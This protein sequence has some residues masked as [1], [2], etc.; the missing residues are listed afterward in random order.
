M[1]DYFERSIRALQLA[2]MSER[3]QQSYTRAVRMLVDF[4]QKT[5]DLIAEPELEDYF[6]HRRNVDKWSSATLR[7]AY[8]G[9]R[10]FFV[11]VLQRDWHIFTYLKSQKDKKLPCILDQEEVFR[12]LGRVKTFHNYACLSTIYAC[13]LRISEAL[14]I[15]VTDID[16]KRMM[17]HVHR[18][19]GAKDRYVPLPQATY[20]LLRSYWVT[21]RNPVFVFPAVGRGHNQAS[22]AQKPMV[23]DS[24]QGA[25]RRAKFDASINK[26]RVS[27]HTLRHCYATHLLEA[28]VN[29]RVVQRYMGHSRLET[30]MVYFHLTQKGT[31]EAVNL[32]NQTMKGFDHDF[33]R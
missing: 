21:H 13:G 5:P 29:P 20:Q 7:I 4:Y 3:T 11:N 8:S 12:I 30:T 28:G 31:E 25:F 23:L 27:V 2:G 14:A 33:N 18:G 6:L 16:G 22:T 15:Q 9:I 32:I 10:F 26:R 24:L 1:K 17:L 19:K